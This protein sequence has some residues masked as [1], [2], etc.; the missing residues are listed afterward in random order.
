M[1][2]QVNH[3]DLRSRFLAR[4]KV[5]AALQSASKFSSSEHKSTLEAAHWHSIIN[6][7]RHLQPWNETS[8]DLSTRR[9]AS[10]GMDLA[11]ANVTNVGQRQHTQP[12]MQANAQTL[13]Q[14]AT[15]IESTAQQSAAPSLTVSQG[16]MQRRVSRSDPL[17]QQDLSTS[18]TTPVTVEQPQDIQDLTVA[19]T[20]RAQ[21][22]VDSKNVSAFPYSAPPSA[23]EFSL[24]GDNTTRTH[25]ALDTF[26]V[27]LGER[28]SGVANEANTVATPIMMIDCQ[29][30]DQHHEFGL[31]C[32][33]MEDILLP[34]RWKEQQQT[35]QDSGS[36][37][38]P[39]LN[40]SQSEDPR[41][42]A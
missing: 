22:S 19:Q 13:Q 27:G 8:A 32:A 3:Q 12:M 28:E 42:D 33:R 30:C 10:A 38:G 11:D 16:D 18:E 4:V 24:R 34:Q 29:L 40:A 39:D 25:S 6:T 41:I 20:P 2:G 36:L 15:S 17:P 9:I 31:L 21:T 23:H 5:L 1:S 14:A 26:Q 7:L 35:R 37:V